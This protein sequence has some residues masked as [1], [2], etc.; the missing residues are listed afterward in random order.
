AILK[1]QSLGDTLS[2]IGFD[3]DGIPNPPDDTSEWPR[4]VWDRL[5]AE[6]P[7]TSLIFNFNTVGSGHWYVGSDDVR[8]YAPNRTG[9]YSVTY[10]PF[11]A[12][13]TSLD[14]EAALIAEAERDYGAWFNGSRN[15]T[16][17]RAVQYTSLFQIFVE[18]GEVAAP[19]YPDR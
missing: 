17:A 18:P 2:Y 19:G 14:R 7:L 6:T 5:N 15:L 13:E 12:G 16:L 4:G 9:S 10:S 8:V 11:G 1:S 3:I